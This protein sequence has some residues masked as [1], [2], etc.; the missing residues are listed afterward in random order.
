LVKHGLFEKYGKSIEGGKVKR[1]I[2]IGI[3]VF[4]AVS[5]ILFAFCSPKHTIEVYRNHTFY[6]DKEFT[7]VRRAL[8]RQDFVK[9]ILEIHDA[10][11]ISKKWL[12]H[13]LE[14]RRPILQES[15]YTGTML[16]IA[17]S[18]KGLGTMHIEQTM[19]VRR[20]K[21]L[22]ITKLDK[23]MEVGVTNWDQDIEIA[24][25]GNRTKFTIKLY[26]K[27]SRPLPRIFVGYAEEQMND[28]A[29]V[30]VYGLEPLL[31]QMAM[32]DVG[33]LDFS[34]PIP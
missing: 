7:D 25:E 23:P 12:R 28:T 11:L 34:I 20:D 33:L 26:A 27:L 16:I 2:V 10:E 5:V 9:E 21:I 19:V 6:V 18:R 30:A 3:F 8:S 24:P 29:D 17:R 1:N 22:N 13:D 14:I 15:E 32:K 4:L 31:R